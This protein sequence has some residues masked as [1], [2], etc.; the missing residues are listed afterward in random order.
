MSIYVIFYFTKLKHEVIC[1]ALPCAVVVLFQNVVASVV[2]LSCAD[3]IDALHVAGAQVIVHIV[4][5]YQTQGRAEN[6]EGMFMKITYPMVNVPY[7]V[8]V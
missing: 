8:T 7:L 3:S 6:K 5:I 4:S 1:S 2:T